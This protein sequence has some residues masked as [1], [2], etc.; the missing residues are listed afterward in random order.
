MTDGHYA[1]RNLGDEFAEHQSGVPPVS[2]EWVRGDVHTQTVEGFFALLKR[3]I[4]GH[5]PPR[6]VRNHLDVTWMSSR[7]WQRPEDRRMGS[8]P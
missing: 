7:S 1:Y 6:W 8:E 5:V 2:N 3:G 4:N